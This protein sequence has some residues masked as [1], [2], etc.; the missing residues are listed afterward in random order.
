MSHAS[1]TSPGTT[2]TN[3][4]G[5]SGAAFAAGRRLVVVELLLLPALP[6]ALVG[7]LFWGFAGL[8]LAFVVAV[9]VLLAWALVLRP[10]LRTLR[11]RTAR[12]GEADRMGN[13]IGGLAR[14]LQRA[15]PQLLVIESTEPNAYVAR[16][17]GSEYLAVTTGLLENYTRT[18]QEA[19]AA[20]CLVRLRSAPLAFS[21]MAA[22]AGKWAF[23]HAPRVGGEDDLA[24]V[25]VTRYPP[26]LATAIEK[27]SKPLAEAPLAFSSVAGCHLAAEARRAALLDL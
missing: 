6:A 7:F 4:W 22:A 12:A 17:M 23:A 11:P 14:D 13:L 8:V 20:H 19:V 3:E 25:A 1:S 24:A 2:P 18:E 16:R 27:A 26:A 5:A 9:A 21:T 10:P 15:A